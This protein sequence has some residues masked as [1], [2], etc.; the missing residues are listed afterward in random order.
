MSQLSINQYIVFNIGGS[1]QN[2][3]Y[4]CDSTLLFMS[5]NYV[6]VHKKIIL[7]ESEDPINMFITYSTGFVRGYIYKDN[8]E[9]EILNYLLYNSLQ[10]GNFGYDCIGICSINQNIFES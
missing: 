1:I 7:S 8:Q 4:V 5:D 2:T 10:I 9:Y 3:V 6:I